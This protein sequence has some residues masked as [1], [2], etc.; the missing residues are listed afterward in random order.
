MRP[1]ESVMLPLAST[2]PIVTPE[3]FVTDPSARTVK[4]PA[5]APPDVAPPM[6]EPAPPMTPPAADEPPLMTLPAVPV[7][8]PEPP[9][10]TVPVE[11]PPVEPPT[12]VPVVKPPVEPPVTVPVEKPPAEPPV[13]KPEPPG[14]GHLPRQCEC[15]EPRINPKTNKII[16]GDIRGLSNRWC[17]GG[18]SSDNS[19]GLS[20][21]GTCTTFSSSSCVT[22]IHC[23]QRK[24]KLH[25]CFIV[26]TDCDS[27]SVPHLYID[28]AI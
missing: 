28:E 23:D 16:V 17:D 5:D 7:E 11:K 21:M 27:T 24:H 1:A 12:T 13:E 25:V 19:F 18:D 8:K 26:C 2:R 15:V 3:A 9:P 14:L 10:V 22:Q 20:N 6:A 4:P